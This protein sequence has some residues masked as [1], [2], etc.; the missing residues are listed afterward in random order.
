MNKGIDNMKKPIAAA[1]ALT[2]GAAIFMGMGSTASMQDV[3][4]MN[5]S[6]DAAVIGNMS[7]AEFDRINQQGAAQVAAIQ[8]TSAPLSKDDQK[9]MMEVAMGGMMQLEVSR[10]GVEKA[11]N[12]EAKILAQSEVEEQTALGNKLREIAAAKN[13]TLPTA[14]DSKTQAMVAKMRERAAGTDF[15]KMYVRDSGVKGHEKLD[16]TMSKVETKATDPAL[17]GVAQAAHPLVRT[18]L[19]VSRDVLA[20]MNGK[21]MNNSSNNRM[22]NNSNGSNGNSNR[23]NGNSNS[24]R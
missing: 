19:Q 2:L 6:A 15:D 20:K 11:T 8:P 10:V 3:R 22:M 21:M 18:H 1:L 4:M 16:K 5:A 12:A 13:V 7:R 24:N 14:P 17:R 9:L 23:T